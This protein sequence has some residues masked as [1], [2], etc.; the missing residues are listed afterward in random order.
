MLSFLKSGQKPG[1][2][3][4]AR[5]KEGLSRTRK[6]LNTDLAD[7]FAGG[8]IDETFYDELENTL[9]LADVGVSAT[10]YLIG[11][12]R[13]AARREGLRAVRSPYV[14]GTTRRSAP[15]SP[16]VQPDRTSRP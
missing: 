10:E 15:S 14:P 9:L 13:G 11:E 7:L 3:W 8:A 12:L 6:V 4:A 16:D 2:G 5:L 1:T